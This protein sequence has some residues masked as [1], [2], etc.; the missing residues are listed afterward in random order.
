MYRQILH[1]VPSTL[2]PA[3]VSIGTI[4]VFTRL[5][6]PAAFGEY[7]LAFSAAAVVL[8]TLF[9][10]L[11]V[12]V[13]RLYLA[14][15]AS[16]TE[17]GFLKS[18]YLGFYLI[19]LGFAVVGAI[20]IWSVPTSASLK[21][22]LWATLPLPIIRG[23]IAINQDL[24][25][26]ADRVG[27]F[28]VVEALQ[29][30]LGFG[31]G[32]AFV[33]L[34]GHHAWS[35]MLGLVLGVA[36][37]ALLDARLLLA[38]FRPGRVDRAALRDL[39]RFGIPLVGT[40]VAGAILP[41]ADRLLLGALG[42]AGVL[43]VYAVAFS[44]VERPTTILATTISTATYP[45]AIRMM[46]KA[47]AE[48]AREQTARGGAALIALTLPACVGLAICAPHAAEVMVGAE[49][50]AGV[51]ALIPLMSC[52]AF[53]R[54]VTIHFLDHVFHL[55]RRSDLM[56][57][58]YGPTTVLNVVLN[59]LTIPVFGAW[60]A[61]GSALACQGFVLIGSVLMS[62]RVFPLRWPVREMGK[63]V[64]AAVVMA[65]ALVAVNSPLTWGGL[66][67]MVGVGALTYGLAGLALDL[68]GARSVVWAALQPRLFPQR[69]G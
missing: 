35:V 6:P 47:G 23:A 12:A 67:V 28:N 27:R 42:N 30:V 4:Y 61:A 24:H 63:S 66:G 7:T 59:V 29:A 51:A 55:S 15:Q 11:S 50:R 19:A 5:L 8:A 69:T 58:I 25:R 20:L 37:A 26:L 3:A 41:Y 57:L 1:Y 38:P 43:G 31:F 40:S 14:A 65:L 13:T 21:L 18:S 46:E 68:A 17:R 2:I 9:W 60:G 62:R 10:P 52:T 54:G 49:Y 56:L 48:A 53:L 16:G 32:L 33:L 44:L 64:L 34:W 36:V 45:M 39:W 22:T